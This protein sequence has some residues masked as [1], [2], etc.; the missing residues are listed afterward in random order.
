MSRTDTPTFISEHSMMSRHLT[1]GLKVGIMLKAMRLLYPRASRAIAIS[2]QVCESMLQGTSFPRDRAHVVH[3][4]IDGARIDALR[5][6]A[7][8]HPWLVDKVTPVIVTAGRLVDEKDQH[9]LIRAVAA[10]VRTQARLVV[11][12]EGPLREPLETLRDDLG[13]QNRVDLPGFASN[14]YAEFGRADVL[15]L[16]SK[17]EGFANVVIE[18]L[19]CGLPVVA[20]RGTGGI[21]DSLEDGQAIRLVDIGDDRAMAAALDSCLDS[22]AP[23]TTTQAIVEP[24]SIERGWEGYRDVVLAGLAGRGRGAE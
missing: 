13:L 15:A 17:S 16:P 22:P 7:P 4:P 9:T 8:T 1:P 14:P 3:N 19:A 12:G 20:M 23:A 10:M 18:A 11:F 21:A 24:F 5:A 2:E 6:E